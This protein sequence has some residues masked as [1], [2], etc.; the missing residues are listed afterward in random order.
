MIYDD[1]NLKTVMAVYVTFYD[2][3]NQNLLVQVY[4][5]HYTCNINNYLV[6]VF[7]YLIENNIKWISTLQ[8][9]NTQP[10]AVKDT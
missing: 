10:R 3:L 2:I 5:I 7:V 6:S 1:N 4:S 9:L 8:I